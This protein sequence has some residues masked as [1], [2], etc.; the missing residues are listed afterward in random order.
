MNGKPFENDE[1]A[2]QSIEDIVE[3]IQ[4]VPMPQRSLRSEELSIAAERY[5][6]LLRLGPKASRIELDQARLR[7]RNASEAFSGEPGLDALLK[8]EAIDGGIK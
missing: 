6:K 3:Y 2:N 8:L 4:G 1:K 5:F 7:Y